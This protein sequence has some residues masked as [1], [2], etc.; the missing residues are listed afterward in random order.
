MINYEDIPNISGTWPNVVTVPASGLGATDGTPISKAM[1]DDLWGFNQALMEAA[2]L[3][4]NDI[5]ETPGYSQRVW[6]LQSLCGNPGEIVAWHGTAT[7]PSLYGIRLL[8]CTGQL[9][10]IAGGYED[11]D[12]IVWCGPGDNDIAPCYY[13]AQ[14]NGTRDVYGDYLRL[15]D[16]RGYVLRG[17][18]GIDE[19]PS[20][21]LGSTQ[22]DAVLNHAHIIASKGDETYSVRYVDTSIFELMGTGYTYATLR[23]MSG[24]SWPV[25]D[26]TLYARENI[27][28]LLWKSSS[29]ENRM[30]NIA[31]HYM[32]RY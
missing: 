18:G 6:A 24:T 5:T 13:H 15:P 32:I 14:S 30:V 10:E 23:L 2:G 19:E 25:A 7:N 20:R 26:D 9:I 4:P 29:Y 11:L 28:G 3:T 31:V 12:D 1:I 21:F 17:L 8:R 22:S 27:P 16:L